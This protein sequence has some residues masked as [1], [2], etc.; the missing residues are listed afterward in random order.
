MVV[1]RKHNPCEVLGDMTRVTYIR[2]RD[3]WL[4]P[5]GIEVPWKT[6]ED[7]PAYIDSL[8]DQRVSWLSR[9]MVVTLYEWVE[10]NGPGEVL[11]ELMATL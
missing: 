1:Y 5:P 2:E 7:L 9:E 6:I 10:L 3:T 4:I 8:D 11:D